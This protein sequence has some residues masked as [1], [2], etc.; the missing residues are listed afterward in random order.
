MHVMGLLTTATSLEN[1]DDMVQSLAVVF[2][3]PSSGA[4]VKTHFNN[5]QLLMLKKGTEVEIDQQVIA[6][7]LQVNDNYNHVRLFAFKWKYINFAFITQNT[8]ANVLSQPNKCYN[9]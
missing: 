8:S 4:N 2:S 5:L 3:S 7:D 6:E 1:L 9:P